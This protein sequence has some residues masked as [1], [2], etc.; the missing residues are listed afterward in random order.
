MQTAAGGPAGGPGC[1]L[2]PE[3]RAF[4][5]TLRF[6]AVMADAHTTHFAARCDGYEISTDPDRLDRPAIHAFLF[7][8]YWAR[9][10]DLATR[11]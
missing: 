1:R 10:V 6:N 11:A 9:G 3:Q 5:D 7:T 4:F 2:L 8:S